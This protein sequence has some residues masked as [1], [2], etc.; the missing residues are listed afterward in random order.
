MVVKNLYISTGSPFWGAAM[1]P[2]PWWRWVGFIPNWVIDFLATPE[3]HGGRMGYGDFRHFMANMSWENFM[4]NLGGVTCFLLF[5]GQEMGWW[6]ADPQ[7]FVY[8][9]FPGVQ[10]RLRSPS[11]HCIGF[12]YMDLPEILPNRPSYITISRWFVGW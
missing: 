2:V 9:C 11:R 1:D 3:F 6:S 7:W 4:I 5:F 12:I 10:G 8:F